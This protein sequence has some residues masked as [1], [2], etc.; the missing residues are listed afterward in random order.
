M[1]VANSNASEFNLEQN[2]ERYIKQFKV[3]SIFRCWPSKFK[4]A[5]KMAELFDVVWQIDFYCQG[6]HLR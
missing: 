4:M 2:D 6:V 1:I 5:A 3:Y